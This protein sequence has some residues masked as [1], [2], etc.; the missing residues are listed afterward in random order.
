VQKDMLKMNNMCASV[1]CT[2]IGYLQCALSQSNI[3]RSQLICNIGVGLLIGKKT[4]DH[5]EYCAEIFTI[6]VSFSLSTDHIWDVWLRY[7]NPETT[8]HKPD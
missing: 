2:F 3:T 5:G 6:S 8:S 7:E 4:F 1:S